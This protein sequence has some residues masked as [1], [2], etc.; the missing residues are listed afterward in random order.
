MDGGYEGLGQVWLDRRT[1]LSVT[2]SETLA[3]QWQH[4]A[5]QHNIVDNSVLAAFLVTHY[6]QT[7][8]GPIQ[9]SGGPIQQSLC[10]L[11]SSPLRHFCPDCYTLTPT[12]QTQAPVAQ[13]AVSAAVDT[14]HGSSHAPP[15][16][17]APLGQHT[18]VSNNS[19]SSDSTLVPS[20]VK[21]NLSDNRIADAADDYDNDTDD[22]YHTQDPDKNDEKV[23]I[24][25]EEED[26]TP[27]EKPPSQEKEKAG[28]CKDSDVFTCDVCLRIFFDPDQLVMHVQTHGDHMTHQCGQCKARFFRSQTLSLHM[29]THSQSKNLSKHTCDQ[30]DCSFTTFH[31]LKK[32]T[33]L[34]HKGDPKPRRGAVR[35]AKT[36]R[37]NSAS[38]PKEFSGIPM[39]EALHI[40]RETTPV[41]EGSPGLQEDGDPGQGDRDNDLQCIENSEEGKEKGA[42]LPPVNTSLNDK[43]ASLGQSLDRKPDET[44][45]LPQASSAPNKDKETAQSAKSS[46]DSFLCKECGKQFLHKHYLDRHALTHTGERRYGCQRC[47]AAFAQL[48]SLVGHMHSHYSRKPFLCGTCHK[49]FTT[50]SYMTRHVCKP[51]PHCAECGETFTTSNQLSVHARSH[52]STEN[53]EVQEDSSERRQTLRGKGRTAKSS[54]RKSTKALK[55]NKTRGRPRKVA[56][57]NE[58]SRKVTQKSG[59]GRKTKGDN[60]VEERA[61]PESQG[62]EGGEKSCEESHPHSCNFCGARFLFVNHLNRHIQDHTGKNAFE[63]SQCHVSCRSMARLEIHMR[64]H[65]ASKDFPCQYCGKILRSLYT[66]KEHLRSHTGERPF[67]CEI[68]SSG[69]T[70]SST[71]KAHMRT[72]SGDRPYLC[73]HCGKSFVRSSNLSVHIRACT[74]E[75]PYACN[76]CGKSFSDVGYYKKHVNNHAG[77]RPYKCEYCGKAFSQSTSL[78]LHIRIHTGEKPY[79]CTECSMAFAIPNSLTEHMRKH[80]GDKPYKCSICGK[81]FAKSCNRLAHFRTHNK[82][83]VATT[84]P[85]PL[86]S[87]PLVPGV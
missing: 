8:S 44:D 27:A 39:A 58:H 21:N 51:A 47:G 11:C 68:C 45:L 7:E 19:I 20:C 1:T 72:H 42:G 37:N 64:S 16:A 32:H 87:H 5:R 65:N 28:S 35:S 60:C 67:R 85:C 66:L 79:K 84:T 43:A 71:Y 22:E 9:T 3:W 40:P 69:F 13:G 80:T 48:T 54:T 73:P 6:Q 41:E 25:S 34:M 74:G 17:S 62:A 82:N 83:K 30:C 52:A 86:L 75:K 49:S 4:I 31:R 76:V 18:T 59:N 14:H 2:L 12:H 81:G 77:I 70:L 10:T 57:Q 50:F 78:K 23:G 26:L 29:K 61:E 56:P 38:S 33:A 53:N 15:A 36:L 55:T 46:G 24:K 63:C